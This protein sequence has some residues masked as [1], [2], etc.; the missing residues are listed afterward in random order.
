MEFSHIGIVTNEKKENE[1]F[2]EATRVWVTDFV[3]HPHKVE[4]L[5]FEPDSPVTGPLRTEPHVAYRVNSI[6][7]ASQGMEV[8][9]EPF[10]AMEG[11]RVGF[12]LTNDGAIVEFMEY[13]GSPFDK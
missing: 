8:V 9:M 6:E 5:R 2:V 12:Y 1:T 11:L 13:E 10:D 3:T 7:E 4:W